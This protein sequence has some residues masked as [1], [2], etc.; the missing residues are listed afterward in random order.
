MSLG[1]VV[2]VVA[3]RTEFL[4]N[5]GEL[6]GDSCVCITGTNATFDERKE[7][8]AQVESGEKNCISGSIQIFKEGIS[9]NRISC[10]INATPGSNPITLEQLIGRAQRQAEGKLNPV[11]IDLQFAGPDGRKH[12]KARLEFYQRKGWEVKSI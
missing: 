8:V 3:D 11:V 12:N 10:I 5:V 2:L 4:E 6:I 9:I 7:L 1:H